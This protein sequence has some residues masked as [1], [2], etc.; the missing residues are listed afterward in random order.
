[1]IIDVMTAVVTIG[2]LGLV[3][4]AG[5]GFA[6]KKFAVEVDERVELVN[7]LLPGANCGG[8][9]FPGCEQL[10]VAMVEGRAAN[11]ACPPAGADG[12]AK[13]AEALGQEVVEG[14][15]MV[16]YIK[17]VGGESKAVFG[18]E[19]SGLGD[20]RSAGML[21][22]GGPKSC[23]YGCLG[24]GSC[25]AVCPFDA[26]VYEDGIAV[27]DEDKCVTC[28]KCLDVCPNNLIELVPADSAFRV[29]CMSKDNAKVVRALCQKGC[30]ACKICV[31]ACE[32]D[33]AHVEEQIAKIDYE[34]CTKCR[35][36]AEKCP[37]KVISGL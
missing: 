36:C 9:G 20:C 10:A 1:M 4:G 25:V 29:G 34:K 28:S 22:G 31:K 5:L 8:C 32:D 17:C 24:M 33:A 37:T 16:A 21:A 23:R 15:R 35:K 27:V 26:I 18:Y 3:L 30:I 12:A 14:K 2:G 13:I 6:G 19:Y 7:S 11:N